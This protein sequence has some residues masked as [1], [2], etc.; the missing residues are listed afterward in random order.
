M[1]SKSFL[2]STELVGKNRAAEQQTSI[3]NL[4]GGDM[5]AQIDPPI[6]QEIWK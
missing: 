2:R 4:G 6:K 1:M 5:F 3:N